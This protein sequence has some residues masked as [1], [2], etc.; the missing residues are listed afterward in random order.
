[1][2]RKRA[3]CGVV[4]LALTLSLF[5]A[6]AVAA[7]RTPDKGAASLLASI[8]HWIE[9]VAATPL[10]WFSGP[11]ADQG[12]QSQTEKVTCDPSVDLL[13]GVG[14]GTSSTDSGPGPDPDG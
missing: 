12:L 5:A 11:S 14:G 6:P 13:C 10:G 4:V 1:M 3:L 7:G 8:Q 9:Q 2:R